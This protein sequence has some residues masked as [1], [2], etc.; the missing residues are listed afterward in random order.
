MQH[1]FKKKYGQN[2]LSDELLL[3]SIVDDSGVDATDC[4]LEIGAGAGALTTRLARVAKKVLSFE[5]DTDLQP[6]LNKNLQ[7]FDNVKVVFG[8]FLRASDEQIISELGEEYAVVANLPYYITAQVVSL[9]V[10]KAQQGQKIKSLTL[11]LQKE[12]AERLVAKPET[13]QYGAITVALAS[14]AQ[15]E[16][17]RNIDRRLFYPVPNVDSAVVTA[18]FCSNRL[19]VNSFDDFRQVTKCAFGQ[20]RKTLC[21]NVM[22]YFLTDRTTAQNWLQL[23]GIDVGA[24]GETL[25]PEQFASLA[26]NLYLLKI[27][28]KN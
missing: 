5:I 6:I 16:L 7:N 25:S 11:T 26:N 12:V 23:N 22:S 18:R 21:N 8:D 24:R 19:G 14:V 17:T 9:F 4:V 10:E 13:K 15:A 20:R 28:P 2:F 1:V 3:Q 27:Q